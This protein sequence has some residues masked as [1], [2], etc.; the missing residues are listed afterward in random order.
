MNLYMMGGGIHKIPLLSN[1]YAGKALPTD[2]RCECCRAH[3]LSHCLI[4]SN[5]RIP[6]PMLSPQLRATDSHVQS[7][8]M[9]S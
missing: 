4:N 5:K 9:C 1:S 7:D 3:I 8:K 2:C 6:S